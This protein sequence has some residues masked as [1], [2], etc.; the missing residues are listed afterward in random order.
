MAGDQQAIVAHD[1]GANDDGSTWRSRWKGK[2]DDSGTRRLHKGER[3]GETTINQKK[4]SSE[5]EGEGE[6]FVNQRKCG[7][8]KNI[9]KKNNQN[10]F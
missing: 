1:E 7:E 9:Y 3:E 4:N 2:E 6:T 8:G 5:G 10:L